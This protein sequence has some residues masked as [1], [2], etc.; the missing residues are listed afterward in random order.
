VARRFFYAKLPKMEE[1]LPT[2]TECNAFCQQFYEVMPGLEL[3]A[4]EEHVLWDLY[5][6]LTDS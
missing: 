4:W 3:T 2:V 6:W 5:G 1:L